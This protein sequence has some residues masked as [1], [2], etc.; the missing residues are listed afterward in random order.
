MDEVNGG[1]DTLPDLMPDRHQQRDPR[2]R[3]VAALGSSFAAGP[4]IEPVA[5]TGAMRSGANNAHLLA[6]TLGA[7]LTDLTVSGATTANILDE[8]QLSRTGV[9]YPPQVSGLPAE[10]DLVTVTAGGN[11]LQ[12]HR[13]HAPCCLVKG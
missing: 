1:A 12:I 10:A 2:V 13:L 11:D 8:P 7:D 6:T 3:L 5:D 4:G 9:R